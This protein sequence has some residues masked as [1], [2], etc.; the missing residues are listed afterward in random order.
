M[1]QSC[2]G[3]IYLL[4]ALQSSQSDAGRKDRHRRGQARQEWTDEARTD[5]SGQKKRRQNVEGHL[6]T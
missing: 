3:I 5:H 6:G 1:S 4:D 2:Q